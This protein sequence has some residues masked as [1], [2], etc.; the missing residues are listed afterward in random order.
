MKPRRN[1]STE[2]NLVPIA[3]AGGTLFVLWRWL[4]RPPTGGKDWRGFSGTVALKA[5]VVY[6]VEM[7]APF[8]TDPA[9][10]MTLQA[11]EDAVTAQLERGGAR[12]V[13]WSI[14]DAGAYVAFDQSYPEQKTLTFG[15]SGI[16]PLLATTARRLDGLDWEAP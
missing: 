6:R 15:K 8:S 10:D 2:K 11:N 4:A 1:D 16:G 12:N 14:R 9:R 13:E 7:T 3:I 5:G